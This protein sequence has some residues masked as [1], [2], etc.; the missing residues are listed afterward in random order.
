MKLSNNKRMATKWSSFVYTFWMSQLCLSLPCFL[1][2]IVEQPRRGPFT[3]SMAVLAA[4]ICI[5]GGLMW[6]VVM[7]VAFVEPIRKARGLR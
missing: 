7:W 4:L 2:F 6:S 3:P 1:F 5:A